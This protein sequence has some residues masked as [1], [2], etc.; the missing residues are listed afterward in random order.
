MQRRPGWWLA[1]LTLLVCALCGCAHINRNG[2]PGQEL[3]A[4]DTAVPVSQPDSSRRQRH[5]P[6]DESDDSTVSPAAFADDTD[7]PAQSRKALVPPAPQVPDGDEDSDAMLSADDGGNDQITGSNSPEEDGV[8]ETGEQ[9]DP[10]VTP[11][12]ADITETGDQISPAVGP[13]SVGATDAS[14]TSDTKGV[15]RPWPIWIPQP[16][17]A[18]GDGMQAPG[19][20][21]VEAAPAP[22]S[23]TATTG[24]S[25]VTATVGPDGRPLVTMHMD[26]L[27]VRKA[28]EMLSRQAGVNILVSP[29]VSGSVTVDLRNVSLDIAVQA[30]VKL[31]NLQVRREGDIIFVS[32]ADEI[33]QGTNDTSG[34]LALRVY[35]LEYAR[36]T[37]LLPMVKPLLTTKGRASATPAAEQG[38]KSDTTKAGGN[39]LSS[40]DVLVVQDYEW[41]LKNVDRVV[42]DLD[43]QPVQVLIE[44]VILNV[45]LNRNCQLGVNYALLGADAHALVV[46]NSG[47]AINS[48]AGF[49]PAALVTAGGLLRGDT[50]GGS[51]ANSAGL[52]FGFVDKDVTGF[53]Q[54]I[55]NIGETEVL[56]TP[57]LLV[58]NKQR[59]EI[60]L[61][62]RLGFRTLTQTQTS[63]V[64]KIEFM[65]VGTQLRMRPFITNDGMVRLEIHP[66]RSSGEVVDNVPSTH[67]T[68]VTTNVIVPDG[69]TVVIGGL[70]DDEDAF[71][72]SGI[73][74]LMNIPYLG[75]LFRL[76]THVKVRK[77]L[78]V[79]LTP[80]IWKGESV[81]HKMLPKTKTAIPPLGSPNGS[82][83]CAKPPIIP[84]PASMIGKHAEEIGAKHYR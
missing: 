59:A 27:D 20:E 80:R 38:I 63:T 52:K 9:I 36:A 72:R 35:R 42:D 37:D 47:A 3:Q 12:E 25:A 26:N 69:A 31:C 60:Q 7:D 4:A 50:N 13:R 77:E 6:R 58:L 74:G 67:T 22:R 71:N 81:P 84:G 55:A 2:N 40:Q 17:D 75:V 61:G 33:N 5:D 8:T 15:P 62:D 21:V 76:D 70:I 82:L 23:S 18:E 45:K 43:V 66:E 16:G 49:A 73:P 19:P 68:E 57:R 54:A 79:L 64:Q 78:V 1:G 28:I 29:G 46:S 56:A 51:A 39:T 14:G 11:E 41:V 24:D 34:G 10:A 48:A 53:I 65:N 30:I 83:E 32:T 44:A